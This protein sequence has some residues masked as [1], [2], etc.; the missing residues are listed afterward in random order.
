MAN[1]IFINKFKISQKNNR[2]FVIAEAGV[3]HFGSLKKAKKLIDLAKDSGAD[4]VKFQAYVTEELIHSGFKKWFYRMKKKEVNFS[5]FEKI[6]KFADGKKITFLL[7]PHSETGIQ[8]IKKLNLPAVKVGSGEIGNFEFLKKII[9]LNRTI[10]IST[11]MHKLEE[12]EK[13]KTF[14]EKMKFKKVVFL[15]CNTQYPTPEKDIN[16]KSFD[17]FK[18]IFKNYFVGY[19]DHTNDDL[20]ILGSIA[21]GAK[22]I[23]KHISLDFNVKD[24]QDWKVSF[25]KFQLNNMVQKIRKF[26]II[27]GESNLKISKNEKKSRIWA[28][29][30]IYSK[31]KLSKGKIITISDVNFLRPGNN[32]SCSEFYKINKRKLKKT[33]LPNSPINLN[34][35]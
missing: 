6:K 29:R 27:L 34:D 20:A 23:E 12:L 24:A 17:K 5:F 16:L 35:F 21:L 1:T 14:F 2:V 28:S 18:E 9:K 33:I 4:A 30:S 31:K 8:W 13:L 11:G 22:V 3:S 32:L 19:S 26:E 10:I 25:D 15:R 7:T